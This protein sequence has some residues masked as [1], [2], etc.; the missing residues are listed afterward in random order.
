MR[1]RARRIDIYAPSQTLLLDG[2]ASLTDGRRTFAA[3][4]LWLRWEGERFLYTPGPVY[5]STPQ[6]ELRGQNLLY[7]FAHR[8]GQ[9]RRVE[10]NYRL[11]LAARPEDLLPWDEYPLRLTAAQAA[12][13]P[14]RLR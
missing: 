10:M 9:L 3:D 1:L 11:P 13:T 2:L 5:L 6:G 14:D 4:H 8:T 12:L 7:D